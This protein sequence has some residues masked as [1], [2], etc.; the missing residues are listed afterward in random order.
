MNSVS[1]E[2]HENIVKTKKKK[3]NMIIK[4]NNKRKKMRIKDDDFESTIIW[5]DD[6]DEFTSFLFS[7]SFYHCQISTKR[8]LPNKIRVKNRNKL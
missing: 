4:A 5:L 6:Q 2:W 8:Y 7:S 1:S 3:R